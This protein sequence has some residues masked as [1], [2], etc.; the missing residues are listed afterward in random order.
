MSLFKPTVPSEKQRER[1]EKIRAKG[2]THF[3]LWRG[4]LGWGFTVFLI[5]SIVAWHERHGW[6]I[7]TEGID[8]QDS[9]M[10]PLR[11]VIWL[12]AGYFFGAS[13]WKRTVEPKP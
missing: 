4:M 1:L 5:T 7:P 10:I 2:R 8:H 11:L 12:V 6:H 13:M 9:V 3:I